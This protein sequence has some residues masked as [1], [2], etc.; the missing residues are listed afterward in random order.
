MRELAPKQ[1][2]PEKSA[3]SSLAR[4]HA[5]AV[6]QFSVSSAPGQPLDTATRTFMESRFR[7]DFS[8]VRIHTGE[9]AAA[10]TKALG[11]LAFSSGSDII[12]GAGRY[13]PHS[14]EGRRL[15]AHELAHVAQQESFPQNDA[16]ARGETAA[17]LE[18][19]QAA[20][21]AAYLEHV[22]TI[23]ERPSGPIQLKPDDDAKPTQPTLIK[24]RPGVT[25]RIENA[26]AA[27]SLDEKQWADL[28]DS[29]Q[30][31]LD[32]GKDDAATRAYLT[33][34]ADVAKLA[35]VGRVLTSTGAIQ[36]VTG[37]KSSC[38]DAKPGLNFSLGNRDQWGADASTGFVH[39]DGK[40]SLVLGKRGEPQPEVVIVLSRSAFKREK[41]QTLAIL[42][43]EM[44]HAEHDA[45]DASAMFHS[46]PKA[47]SGPV[48]T[49]L[50]N[51][52]LLAY[53]EGFMTMFHLTHPAPSSPDHPAFVQ[54]LGAVDTG[55]VHPWAEAD[56]AFRS[57][58]LGRLQE[59][60]CHALD[61]RHREAFEGWVLLQ[62]AEV[63]KDLIQLGEPGAFSP[64]SVDDESMKV[65]QHQTSSGMGAHI[66]IQIHKKDDFVGG[67]Q[68][69]I[70]GHCKG[71][72]AT[73][74]A[75][76]QKT[77]H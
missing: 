4:A 2:Q 51:S 39:A 10:S 8:R 14:F 7:H 64:G 52:E 29:A 31:A 36:V 77:A 63:Q 18:A 37:D 23:R 22:P 61:T 9:T 41:E 26:Y 38:R 28:I 42:R 68:R 55:D 65:L 75:V 6:S 20:Q 67:L 34:Y 47:K 73:P 74:M 70:A 27:G 50:A 44:V 48:Q 54:L 62:A 60:Y 16:S 17:E 5:P 13:V 45:E 24:D 35:Q 76:G 15:L 25:D 1:R 46:D 69:V 72:P 3:P 30:Q 19:D 57:E 43:H 32:K 58:A 33:L 56:K 12:F 11:A 71:L 49:S 59:Y 40:L 21:A 53:F 66:R